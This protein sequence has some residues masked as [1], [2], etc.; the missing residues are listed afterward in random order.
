ME[1]AALPQKFQALS[2]AIP[3]AAEDVW[4]R[5]VSAQRPQIEQTMLLLENFP[6]R[7][8]H[9]LRNRGLELLGSELRDAFGD[10]QEALQRHHRQ[11]LSLESGF[12]ESPVLL[13]H[14]QKF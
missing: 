3:E 6:L 10:Q 1:A 9:S 13:I 8:L 11:S 4:A 2:S 12:H 5:I 14:S 7:A